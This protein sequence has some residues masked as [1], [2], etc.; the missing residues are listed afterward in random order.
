MKTFI[1]G[2]S[3]VCGA[4]SAAQEADWTAWRWEAPVEIG[5]SGMVRLEVP[6]VLL[7]VSR[8]DL[9]DLR[10]LSPEG[11]ET[12][13]LVEEPVRRAGGVRDAAEFKVALSGRNTVI[14]VSSGSA[15]VIEAVQLVTPARDFIKA[16]NIDGRASGGEW[17]K[18]A[19]NEVIFRQS[20]DVERLRIPI[21]AGVWEGFRLTVDDERTQPVPITGVR[22]VSSAEKP[23][24]TELPVALGERKEAGGET[25]LALDLGAANLHVAEL[26][27]VIADAVFS[28][29]CTLGFETSTPDGKT[30]METVGTGV[31]YRVV[32]DR[33]TSA[34]ELVIPVHRRIPNRHLIAV[35]RN[36]DSP[37]LTIRSGGVRC[38]PTVLA[39]HAAQ[40]G[41]W[42]LITGN[43]GAETPGYD[44]N[45][46]RGALAKAGGQG[47]L[48]GPPRA[49]PDYRKPPALPGVEPAGAGI[50]L[51]GWSRRRPVESVTT[52]VIRIELDSR[53]LAG[54]RADLGDLRL[55]QNGRQIPYL[56]KP[57]SVGRELKASA[58][59]LPNDPKSPTLSRWKIAL[60][61]D[62]V[63][64]VDLTASSPAPMF[65]RRLVASV[66]R[67]DELG[68]SWREELGAAD[69]TK[70]EGAEVPLVLDLHGRR[71]PR[72]FT[73]ET[74]HGDNPPIAVEDVTVRF[75]APSI[76]A[77]L[78]DDA[79]LF[80][81]YG[82]PKVAAPRYD[83]RLVRSALMAADQQ[84]AALGD[85][86]LLK[87]DS[88]AKRG[89]HA[90]SP[91]L[92]LALGGVVVVLLVIV[93]RLLPRPPAA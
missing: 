29:T 1:A 2:L 42:R 51:A 19:E 90:G 20:G 70:S 11:A 34:E 83:L 17:R 8:A 62:G 92:W 48:P 63:P 58:I 52:G 50:D 25:R 28:R 5:K 72:E 37:P 6:S 18:L 75:A 31:L 60:P 53:T 57:D 24:T 35:F 49:K 12:S 59:P 30:R 10:V 23:A 89:V 76:A 81:Y 41:T 43:P 27:F 69:W 33:G 45:P 4:L 14:E 26:R 56:I 79:P 36:G 61:V 86:E 39:F 68:N 74:D 22:V 78:T 15:G 66:V 67:K 84:A 77:K 44:L 47:V 40:A 93:A 80:L 54:C 91:W 32:G 13:Y 85:E 71:L 7:D 65:T 55:I 21:P 88:E 9:G 3:L 16:V 38:D 73:L 64:A 46:L 82:N 87:P